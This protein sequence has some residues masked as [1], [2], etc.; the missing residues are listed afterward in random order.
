[1]AV[2]ADLDSAGAVS[3]AIQAQDSNISSMREL[4]VT[5]DDA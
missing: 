2:I 5:W 1:M 4:P 3:F